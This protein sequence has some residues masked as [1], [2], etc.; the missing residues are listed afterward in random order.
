MFVILK[1]FRD[2]APNQ[3]AINKDGITDLEMK[4]KII[5]IKVGSIDIQFKITVF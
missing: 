1:L 5:A 2:H 3:I 4:A